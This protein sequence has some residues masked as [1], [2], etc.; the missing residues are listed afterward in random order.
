MDVYF[1]KDDPA[2]RLGYPREQKSVPVASARMSSLESYQTLVRTRSRSTYS[3]QR[4]AT[5]VLERIFFCPILQFT[6]HCENKVYD[7]NDFED[8]SSEYIK[9]NEFTLESVIPETKLAEETVQE[10]VFDKISQPSIS[11]FTWKTDAK[12]ENNF[13]DGVNLLEDDE[14][15]WDT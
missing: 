1:R 14:I 5:S 15:E 10:V 7:P 11:G 13:D 3:R 2:G 4:T 9:D 6:I 8:I 12:I